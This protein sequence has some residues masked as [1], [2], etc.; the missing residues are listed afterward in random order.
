MKNTNYTIGIVELF[1]HHEVVLNLCKVLK[2]NFKLKVFVSESVFQKLEQ[3]GDLEIEFFIKP[4]KNSNYKFFSSSLEDFNKCN[5]LIFTT[6]AS[7]FKDF[8]TLKV[9]TKTLLIIHNLNAFFYPYSHLSFV[10]KHHSLFLNIGRIVRNVFFQREIYYKRKLLE[11]LDFISFPTTQ[12][13]QKVIDE[14]LYPIEKICP[15]LLKGIIQEKEIQ[16]QLKK[17]EDL[18]SIV[19]PGTIHPKNKDYDIVLKAFQNIKSN[20]NQ[21]V[22]IIF[23]GN[24]KGR[25]GENIRKKFDRIQSE[26]IEV[27]FLKNEITR[28]KYEYYLKKADFF[29]LSFPK[30][31]QYS[32]YQEKYGIT[33]ASGA[34]LYDVNLFRTPALVSS[35]YPLEENHFNNCFHF[36]SDK[37]LSEFLQDWINGQI[38]SQK[39]ESI[40]TLKID[41]LEAK[42]KNIIFKILENFE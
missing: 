31:T 3:L 7:S 11:K 41:Q 40:N 17:N 24:V 26:K 28:E 25:A 5:L 15:P 37:E 16:N 8:Y 36:K 10:S 23:L 38:F 14:N 29:I 32:I 33:K 35:N 12:I 30:I 4:P 22:R 6:I 42:F 9:E 34:M 21:Q 2:P 27:F 39:K 18:V 19:L 13:H 20:L 1:F